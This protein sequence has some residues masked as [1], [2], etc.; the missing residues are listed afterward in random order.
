MYGFDP[1]TPPNF[2]S[3]MRLVSQP[4]CL[5][6]ETGSI[7][8]EGAMPR[9]L[10]WYEHP[11]EA[12][13]IRNRNPAGAPRAFSSMEER[14]L[15]KRRTQDRYLQGLLTTGNPLGRRDALQATRDGFDSRILHQNESRPRRS[16]DRTSVYGTENESSILSEATTGCSC[17]RLNWNGCRFPK[18]EFEGSSPSEHTAGRMGIVPARPHK[19]VQTPGA[20]PVPATNAATVGRRRA[21]YARS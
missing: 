20:T 19:P 14:V 4:G 5:P 16:T 12:R 17:S 11:V 15:Y 18:P 2:C 10:E 21:S 6:G 7:P 9:Q 3:R 13:E 1:R 8:V